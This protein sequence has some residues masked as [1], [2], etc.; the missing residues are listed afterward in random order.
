MGDNTIT[1]RR[2]DGVLQTI[3]LTDR[4]TIRTSAGAAYEADLKTGDRV[5]LVIDTSETATTVLVCNVASSET[6]SGQ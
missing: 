4:T 6:Q 2:N 5:T 3:N 1:I